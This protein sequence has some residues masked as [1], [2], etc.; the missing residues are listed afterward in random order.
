MTRSA[1]QIF[2]EARKMPPSERAAYLRGACGGDAA[3]WADVEGLLSADAQA[4]EF[5]RTSEEASPGAAAETSAA[6]PCEQAGAQIGR[7]K[8]LQ[9]IGEGGFGSVWLAEQRDPVKRRVALKII[10]LGMDTRQVIARFEAERQALAMMDHPNIAKVLDAGATETG[11]PYFVMEYIKGVPILEYCDT[12]TMDT[13]A[14]LALFSSVC[15]AIQHAHQKGI[16]HRDIKPSNVLVTMHDGVPVPKVIDF[17][18][19]KAT[20]SE[21]TARTL[22]TEHRQMIGTPAYMSPEQ[23]EISGL[24]IDT[25]SDIYSLGVLLYELLT[26]TTPFDSKELLGKGF[27]EMMRIIREVEP[28]K[29]STRLSSLGDTGARTAQ[30]RHL[31]DIKKLGLLLRG[32]LDW[33][34]MKCLEKDRTRRYETA[35]GLAADIKRHLNNEP[36]TAGAPS[37]GYKLRKFVKR[38]RAQ[39]MAG[40][41]VAAALLLGVVGTTTGLVWALDEKSRADAERAKAVLAAESAGRSEKQARQSEREAR[42]SLADSY[43]AQAREMRLRREIGF[44][45][46]GLKLLGQAAAVRGS[47]LELRNEALATL[48]Q[49]DLVVESQFASA[50]HAKFGGSAAIKAGRL[51]YGTRTGEFL[52]RPRIDTEVGEYRIGPPEAGDESGRADLSPD[53]RYLI[54]TFQKR[55]SHDV[56]LFGWD[57]AGGRRLWTQPLPGQVQI[58]GWAFN[59][60]SPTVAI[61]HPDRTVRTHNLSDGS[62]VR[63]IPVDLPVSDLLFLR[64]GA[65]DRFLLMA[66]SE[67]PRL[68]RW[69]LETGASVELPLPGRAYFLAQSNDGRWLAVGCGDSRIVV[70]RIDSPDPFW[71]TIAPDSP[72][73]PHAI[74]SGHL[75]PLNRLSFALDGSLL[76]SS[77]VDSSTRFWDVSRGVERFAPALSTALI[78]VDAGR[79]ALASGENQRVGLWRLQ[80]AEICRTLP[81]H[82]GVH[83]FIDERWFADGGDA[84]L[85]IWDAQTGVGKTRLYNKRVTAVHV[86][87]HGLLAAT[88]EGLL[89]WSIQHTPQG[90]VFVGPDLLREGAWVDMC[91]SPDNTTAFVSDQ[92]RVWRIPLADPESAT[93][94]AEHSGARPKAVSPDGAR[95]VV[96]HWAGNEVVVY[97]VA[98]GSRLFSLPTPGIGYAIGAFTPPRADGDGL[99]IIATN[100]RYHFLDGATYAERHSVPRQGWLAS[101]AVSPD[102]AMAMITRNGSTPALIDLRSF[103]VLA[104][105]T[106]PEPNSTLLQPAF[107]PSG[108][109]LVISTA[110]HHTFVWDL[111]AMRRQLGQLG[112]DWPSTGGPLR[113]EAGDDTQR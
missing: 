32:D 6:T 39:V 58:L 94:L 34:V 37:A 55:F 100:E 50:R 62:V 73:L 38:N 83:A 108:S 8:L 66:D 69:D 19:A 93:R 36:V 5:L 104:E 14:R 103:D 109:T 33:I 57:V 96:G 68:V 60:K 20:S 25:R 86:L 80:P 64:I 95:L 70:Y 59:P 13:K 77:A 1:E 74:L 9:P 48:A 49:S 18:I 35:N 72:A 53:G 41:V 21:L 15:H 78:G 28:H 16:I 89:R 46:A 26:G 75:A 56:R 10:K 45:E 67:R 12:D 105:L 112:L 110:T 113:K 98:D 87:P 106:L 102:G 88:F 81:A 65:G 4:G 44:R 11:R 47:T 3:L 71:P 92:D 17:G 101:L 84:G 99:L 107:D 7:Y 85:T 76:I 54:G 24:D 42:F 51:V 91:V 29:P 82:S 61:G 27:A 2:H 23:A 31:G 90:P 30:Q 40:G 79:I 22:F 97:S 52:V 111:P 63:V 43:L